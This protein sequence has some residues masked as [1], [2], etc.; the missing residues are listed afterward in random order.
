MSTTGYLKNDNI[1]VYL[2]VITSRTQTDVHA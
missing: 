2:Y 1:T